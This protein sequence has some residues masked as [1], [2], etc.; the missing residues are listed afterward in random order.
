MF[1]KY[2][3][4][5]WGVQCYPYSCLSIIDALRGPTYISYISM[6][7]ITYNTGDGSLS[8]GI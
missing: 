1:L 3:K 2:L 7:E 4:I 8:N 6:F 5:E